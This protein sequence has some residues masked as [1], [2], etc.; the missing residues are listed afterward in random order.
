M[1]IMEERLGSTVE[2]KCFC[3]QH[4]VITEIDRAENIAWLACP[5]YEA[6]DDQHDSYSIPL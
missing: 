6:G 5:A 4:L 2:E 1:K 3:G